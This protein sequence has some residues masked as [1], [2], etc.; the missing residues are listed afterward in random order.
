MLDRSCV[1]GP[2]LKLT[3]SMADA[4]TPVRQHA[5]LSSLAEGAR[6]LLR[7]DERRGLGGLPRWRLTVPARADPVVPLSSFRMVGLAEVQ[8]KLADRWPQVSEKVHL[9]AQN[10]ISK[11]LVRGDVFER[12]GDD[13]Y[14]VLFAG[15]GSAEAE[16]KSRVI[17]NEIARHLLGDSE[18]AGI[19]VTSHCAMISAVALASD[20]EAALSQALE[21]QSPQT[22]PAAEQGVAAADDDRSH[23]MRLPRPID[24]PTAKEGLRPTPCAPIVGAAEGRTHA[25]SPIWDVAQMTLL[26]FRA[27]GLGLAAANEAGRGEELEGFRLDLALIRAVGADLLELVDSGRRLPVTIALRHTSLCAAT[28]RAELHRALAETPPALRKLIT[29]EICAPQEVFW[30]YACKAFFEATHPLGVGWSA[31]VELERTNAIPRGAA[32]LRSVG[33]LLAGRPGEDAQS[34]RLMAAF[35]ARARE[36]G[37]ICA[38]YGLESRALV[39]AAIG[40]GFRFLAG[41]AIHADITHLKNAVKFKPLDLYPDLAG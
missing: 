9:I 35:G 6:R 27:V 8:A 31:A 33:A 40:A 22:R 20:G 38:A 15:L 13:G 12:L 25:Y 37:L 34:M 16:F 24:A 41:P 2:S 4:N 30:T 10:T 3:Q 7:G 32:Q 5:F 23:S 11:H 1:A 17:A 26:R 14:L 29:L 21:P 36:L 28:Q 18:A 19:H 39:L